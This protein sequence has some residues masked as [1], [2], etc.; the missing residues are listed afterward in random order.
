LD[1]N[2]PG[3]SA[4]PASPLTQEMGREEDE[5]EMDRLN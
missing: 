4:K 1:S 5:E 3:Q 2:D